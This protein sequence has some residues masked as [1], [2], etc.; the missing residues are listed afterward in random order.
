[1]RPLPDRDDVCLITEDH[2]PK[3]WTWFRRGM[4]FEEFILYFAKWFSVSRGGP[5]AAG[6]GIRSD[7]SL[8]RFRTII[9][10][11]KERYL[12]YPWTTRIKIHDKPTDCWNFLS[13][14]RLVGRR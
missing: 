14:L 3:E 11:T 13:H 2:Y 7:E 8:N 6:I 10:N 12:D 9:S 4:E 5:A 1:M